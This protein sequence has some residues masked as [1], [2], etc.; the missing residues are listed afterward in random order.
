[1]NRNF[2]APTYLAIN[3]H[4]YVI[5]RDQELSAA[6]PKGSGPCMAPVV[7][8]LRPCPVQSTQI[9]YFGGELGGP[10][11]RRKWL[12]MRGGAGQARREAPGQVGRPASR[13]VEG[14]G[15]CDRTSMTA[16]RDCKLG[17]GPRPAGSG[18]PA[19]T[20]PVLSIEVFL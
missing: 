19:V 5:S 4:T 1:M 7:C 3:I 15:P 9:C 13:R 18:D 10:V 8:C 11:G 20:H 12:V 6:K 2:W 17:R 14:A 16:H